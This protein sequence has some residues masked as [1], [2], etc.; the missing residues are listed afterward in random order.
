[1]SNTKKKLMN[2]QVDRQLHDRFLAIC[3]DDCDETGSKVIRMF[4]KEFVAK[5]EA[6]LSASTKE[7]EK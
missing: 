4:I 5:S 1:M 3:R 7:T 2:V 6:E